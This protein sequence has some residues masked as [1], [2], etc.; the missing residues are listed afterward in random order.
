MSDKMEKPES[1]GKKAIEYCLNLLKE[2]KPE[3]PIFHSEADFQFALAW[4]LK[5]LLNDEADV[6]LEYPLP[7]FVDDLELK[8]RYVDV[9]V[10]ENGKMFPIEVKYKTKEFDYSQ[11]NNN[12]AYKLKSHSAHDFGRYDCIKDIWRVEKLSEHLDSFE[13]GYT[14]WLT[15]D[16]AYW[17]GPKGDTRDV[18]F[19]LKEECK[20]KESMELKKDKFMN[21]D[22]SDTK[23]E[24]KIEKRKA[25][26]G[27]RKGFSLKN[28]YSVKW[29][30]WWSLPN[31]DQKNKNGIFRYV[32][33]QIP[34]KKD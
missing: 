30:D 10:I 12:E 7:P 29:L 11:G 2:R 23:D 20:E 27:E 26:R 15:N 5:K 16:N 6:R 14:I 34:P 24:E 28:S 31:T 33:L 3:P 9:L 21:W 32:F 13:E 4:E 18:D 22:D 8:N 25:Y 19:S 17:T 1:M